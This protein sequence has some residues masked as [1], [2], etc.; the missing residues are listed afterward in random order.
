MIVA[1]TV[2]EEPQLLG[3]W[4]GT[5]VGS[6]LI[7]MVGFWQ[8][9]LQLRNFNIEH[10]YFCKAVSIIAF[11]RRWWG[12]YFRIFIEISME[13]FPHNNIWFP[14]SSW[15]LDCEELNSCFWCIILTR[16]LRKP[17]ID[18]TCSNTK[19]TKPDSSTLFSASHSRLTY[20]L[21]TLKY[22]GLSLYY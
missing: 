5:Y 22:V 6:I 10:I 3:A 9:F 21:L 15:W 20:V 18:E 1:E 14:V 8:P 11:H 13:D 4:N 16:M 2:T 17:V 7:I 12:V 19:R